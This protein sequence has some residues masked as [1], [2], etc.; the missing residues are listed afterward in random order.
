VTKQSWIIRSIF[1][2]LVINVGLTAYANPP[3][4]A[5]GKFRDWFHSLKIPGSPLGCCTVADCRMVEA[6]WNGQTQQYEARVI[7]EVFSDALRHSPLYQNDDE[8]YQAA[9]K[10]WMRDWTANYGDAA[11]V[12][13]EIPEARIN[14]APNPTGHSV[15]C[16]SVFSPAFNGVF[17]FVPFSAE[18]N[19]YAGHTRTYV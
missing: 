17:C 1:S 3:P 4:D 13:I 18:H 16:W 7:R 14:R 15:L 5:D 19:D 9:K 10:I 8:A 6:R 11:E 12:W 2:A